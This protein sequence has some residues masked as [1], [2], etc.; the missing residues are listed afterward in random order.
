[1]EALPQAVLLN[2][3]YYSYNNSIDWVV[4]NPPYSDLDRWLTHS[5][6]IANQGVALLLG[7]LNV[8]PRRLEMA[9]KAGFGL[10][11]IHL[12]KVYHW[13]GISAFC[14]WRRGA[15]DII[16]YIDPWGRKEVDHIEGEVIFGKGEY[17]SHAQGADDIHS[18]YGWLIK[19]KYNV[20]PLTQDS[21]YKVVGN[22]Y[23]NPELLKK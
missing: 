22:I 2:G 6:A 11:S 13:F 5:F 8:T 14:V 16:K 7:L 17:S 10:T 9:N 15:G 1:K 18:Y 21:C 23:S 19:D 4:T 12:C 3:D 20:K